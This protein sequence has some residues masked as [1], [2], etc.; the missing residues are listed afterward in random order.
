M[1]V[2]VVW[3]VLGLH[4]LCKWDGEAL[5]TREPAD[6]V[7]KHP[8]LSANTLPTGRRHR[9]DLEIRPAHR[10]VAQPV[11]RC[12][13]D[14]RPFRV[15]VRLDSPRVSLD[16]G[17]PQRVPTVRLYGSAPCWGVRAGNTYDE[18]RVRDD[19]V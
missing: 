17:Q 10:R 13:P 8:P 3:V 4:G 11:R 7:L 6:L 16:R 15:P 1:V 18:A 9:F 19:R 14:H 12:S 5:L 2:R